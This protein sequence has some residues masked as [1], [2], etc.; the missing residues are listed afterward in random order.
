MSEKLLESF[1][2]I[3]KNRKE[4]G[5][6]KK[7]KL[8]EVALAAGLKKGSLRRSRS[9]NSELVRLIDAFNNEI[10]Q[11]LNASTESKCKVILEQKQTEEE[12]LLL[13]L[14]RFREDHV[15][16]INQEAFYGV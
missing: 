14:F 8:D 7:I 5:I 1:Y 9:G 10:E 12:K 2:K 13:M 4:E 3:E 16:P 15:C 11:A 6:L